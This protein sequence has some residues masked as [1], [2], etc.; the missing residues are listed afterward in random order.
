[1]KPK[2][3]SALQQQSRLESVQKGAY[4][5]NWY[6]G[7]LPNVE[8]EFKWYLLKKVS[9]ISTLSDFLNYLWLLDWAI[10]SARETIRS[11]KTNEVKKK[12]KCLVTL[13]MPKIY[14]NFMGSQVLFL[15]LHL[16]SQNIQCWQF[17]LVL[18]FL[19]TLHIIYLFQQQVSWERNIMYSFLI[20]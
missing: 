16:A 19:M 4:G 13:F 3:K 8:R 15:K 2:S 11:T 7:E 20:H 12:T 14:L 10:Q 17:S 1:M 9:S 5:R 6:C 18:Y